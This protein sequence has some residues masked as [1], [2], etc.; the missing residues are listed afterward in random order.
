M[1]NLYIPEN[2]SNNT[3]AKP[4]LFLILSTGYPHHCIQPLPPANTVCK[5][6]ISDV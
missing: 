4:W 3:C 6:I 2:S 1:I 5:I